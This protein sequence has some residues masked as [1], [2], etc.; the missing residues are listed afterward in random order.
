[1][2]AGALSHPFRSVMRGFH[3]VGS[4]TLVPDFSSDCPPFRTVGSPGSGERMSNLMEQNLG[5]FVCC[6][7]FGEV[8]RHRNA[9]RA[10]IAL[11]KPCS[12]SVKTKRPGPGDLVGTKKAHCFLFHPHCIRHVDRLAGE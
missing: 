5:D 6:C 1:M 11:A 12:R 10:V 3:G 8:A 9:L 4:T 2:T 7:F